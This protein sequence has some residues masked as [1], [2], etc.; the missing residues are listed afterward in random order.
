M[1]SSTACDG[2]QIGGVFAKFQ[3]GATISGNDVQN[4]VGA[5]GISDLGGTTIMS[6]IDLENTKASTVAANKVHFMNYNG[7]STIKVFALNTENTTFNTS[8]NASANTF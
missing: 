4:I 1:G 3:T 7:S 2:F 8:S 5:T 6:A